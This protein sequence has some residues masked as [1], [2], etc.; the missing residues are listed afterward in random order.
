MKYSVVLSVAAYKTVEV[1]ANSFEE[2]EQKAAESL[3]GLV[4]EEM[5]PVEVTD[6]YAIYACSEIGEEKEY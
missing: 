2:A 4:T 6:V 1:D 5:E 3:P